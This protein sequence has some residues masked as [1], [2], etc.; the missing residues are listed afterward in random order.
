MA[1][2]VRSS[3]SITVILGTVLLALAAFSTYAAAATRVG[4]VSRILHTAQAVTEGDTHDLS[5][6]S[7]IHLNDVI[8]TGEDARLEITFTDGT[9]VTLGENASLVIDN[10][11]YQPSANQSLVDLAIKGAFRF[12]TGQAGRLSQS[13]IAVRTP[14]AIIG[15]RGTDFFGGPLDGQFG[16]L[17]F[18]GAVAVTN[19]QGE[20]VLDRPGQ[21]TNI[22]APGQP[23]GPVAIWPS[24]KVARALAAVALQ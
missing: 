23:P 24:D 13:T 15:V 8:M 1:Q 4:Q 14:F 9:L 11:V 7:D 19:Q 2:T 12:I 18:E 20:A 22:A 6:N 16:V 21:G 3:T 17:L 10:F 5:A